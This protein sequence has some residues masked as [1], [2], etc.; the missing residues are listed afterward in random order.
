L[1]HGRVERLL[2]RAPQYAVFPTKVKADA[3][4]CG[5]IKGLATNKPAVRSINKG[6]QDEAVAALS[7]FLFVASRMQARIPEIYQVKRLKFSL[8]GL[9]SGGLEQNPGQNSNR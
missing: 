7:V 6:A 4:R 1:I 9:Q 2:L 5:R 3:Q 8:R